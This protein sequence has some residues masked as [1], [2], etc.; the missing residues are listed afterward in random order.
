MVRTLLALEGKAMMRKQFRCP[1]CGSK[2]GYRSHPQNAAEKYLLPLVLLQPLRCADCYRR[3]Y[4][5]SFTR[6]R[7]NRISRLTDRHAA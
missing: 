4:V 7:N 1:D 5:S 3:L 6:I 2:E